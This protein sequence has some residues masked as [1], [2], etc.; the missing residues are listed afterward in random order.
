MWRTDLSRPVRLTLENGLIAAETSIFDYGCGRGGDVERLARHG[1][2]VSG[3]DPNHRPTAALTT[4]DVVNIGYVVNVIEE[5]RERAEALRSAWK[6]A[7][8]LLVVS[9]Q[10]TMDAPRKELT[11]YRD[12]YLTDRNTFQK[13]FEQQEL[14]AWI[15]QT[16]GVSSIPAAPGVFY[17]F[18]DPAQA[19]SYMAS[20]IRRRLA[21]PRL[22]K[23]DVLYEQHKQ[24][25]EALTAF[26]VQRGRLPEVE[27]IPEGQELV[28]ELGSLK[29]AFAVV[30]RVTG[31]EQWEQIREER[32]QDLLVYLA[33]SRFEGRPNFTALPEELQLDVRAHFS[34]YTKACAAAD[35]LLFSA[36]DE[37]KVNQACLTSPIGKKTLTAL[38]IHI[39]ALSLLPPLLRVY[40][41]CA[42]AYVGS[43]EDANILKLHRAKPQVS[44]LSYPTFERDAHPALTESLKVRFTGLRI[45]YR[46][47]R[48]SENPF[49]LHRKETFLPPDHALRGKFENLT[50][51][52]EARGLLDHTA[53]IGTRRGWESALAAHR[54]TIMGHRLI[55]NSDVGPCGEVINQEQHPTTSHHHRSQ[56]AQHPPHHLPTEPGCSDLLY[57]ERQHRQDG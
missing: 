16:L 37:A 56:V 51:Q 31:E 39:D 15:D 54:L 35:E 53:T 40:E 11:P 28:H 44:Y 12:G 26:F 50:K 36:G 5:P 21:A 27:E 6:L 1:H 14:R 32:M 42:R 48:E 57:P 29:R 10:L 19:Q 9:A 52:E 4:A 23:S 30:R 8:R 46:D 13:Y 38:Y 24:M 25:L 7:Q 43:V 34:S 47:Y 18:R 3:W 33:L 55:V 20:R 41:G 22:R 17:V 45:E 49:I 2:R